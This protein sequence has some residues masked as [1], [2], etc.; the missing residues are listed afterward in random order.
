MSTFILQL[1]NLDLLNNL[2]DYC[3]GIIRSLFLQGEL[4]KELGFKKIMELLGLFYKV[5]ELKGEDIYEVENSILAQLIDIYNILGSYVDS[6]NY[7]MRMIEN[8][9][10]VL[11]RKETVIW[12]RTNNKSYK[13]KYEIEKRINENKGTSKEKEW[14]RYLDE[15]LKILEEK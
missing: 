12:A 5:G 2:Y 15:V 7:M 1:Q 6:F 10:W 9:S 14:G 13:V 3:D 4:I 8:S 11:I